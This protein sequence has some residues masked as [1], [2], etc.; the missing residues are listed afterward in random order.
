MHAMPFTAAP[1]PCPIP[2]DQINAVEL[3]GSQLI[4]AFACAQVPADKRRARLKRFAAHHRLKPPAVAAEAL[5]VRMALLGGLMD[6]VEAVEGEWIAMCEAMARI[7]LE[8]G[9][10]FPLPWGDGV[11]S[12]DA[13][14]LQ[15]M[16]WTYE[17]LR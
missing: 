14:R 12:Y 8:D 4:D 6:S 11:V 17:V 3:T 13:A 5:S 16:I 9:R 2:L 15:E 7:R 1:S 10:D